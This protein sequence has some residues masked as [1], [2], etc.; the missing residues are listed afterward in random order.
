MCLVYLLWLRE[1]RQNPDRRNPE[2]PKNVND[3]LR[4]G[5]NILTNGGGLY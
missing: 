4:D 5:R 1:L 2:W 3:E